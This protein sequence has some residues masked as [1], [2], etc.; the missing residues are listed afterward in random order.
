MAATEHEGRRPFVPRGRS[1]SPEELDLLRSLGALVGKALT[2][3]D[4]LR[5]Q[6]AAVQAAQDRHL[7]GASWPTLARAL[8]CA[9]ETLRR[10]R[11]QS[12]APKE[13]PAPAPSSPPPAPVRL[14]LPP[15]FNDDPR[16]QAV[17]SVS[18]VG[19]E[20]AYILISS[21]STINQIA[22]SE[23]REAK[24]WPSRLVLFAS[25]DAVG[26]LHFRFD[27]EAKTIR[28]HL[29]P[30]A[31]GV[32]PWPAIGLAQITQ[33]IDEHR[34]TAFHLAAHATMEGV[35]LVAG[36]RGFIVAQ[37]DVGCALL[38]AYHRPQLVVLSFCNSD[39]LAAEL[40]RHL[41]FVV[42]W[43]GE[44]DDD[45][46]ILFGATFYNSLCRRTIRAAFGD[47]RREISYAYPDIGGPVLATRSGSDHA[48]FAPSCPS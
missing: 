26:N 39:E 34:P 10:W 25:G 45:Q 6:I 17:I 44:V 19:R 3:T 29:W 16:D 12:E 11:S 28:N 42:G 18:I 35:H 14:Y 9:P 8:G 2:D 32:H 13:V 4:R 46:A 21:P 40:A 41:P 31:V 37:A 30:A 48:P 15:I 43:H 1:L 5:L 23:P 27:L 24:A 38:A 33:A 47:A 36:D 20:N 7:S 22:S